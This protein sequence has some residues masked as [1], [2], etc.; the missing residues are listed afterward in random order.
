MRIL[1]IPNATSPPLS[2]ELFE[3]ILESEE[4]RIDF[5]ETQLELLNQVGLQNWLQ[6]WS[7][8]AG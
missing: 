6:T 2:R 3:E 7:G 4:E 5:L 1:S 8:A